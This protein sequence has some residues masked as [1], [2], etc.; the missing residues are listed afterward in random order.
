MQP[1]RW[2]ILGTGNIANQFAKGL[3]ALEDA[4]L[5]AIGSRRAESAHRF[6]DTYNVPNRH[7]SYEALAADP[8]VEIVYV[9]TPH[10]YHAEN[11]LLCLEAG[12]GVLCEKPFTLN[13][14]QARKVI[15]FARQRQLFLME[16]V[17]ARFLPHLDEAMRL[18]ADG[19]IGDVTML[20]ANFG[21][22]TS[23]DP[24]SRLFD[25]ALGG[26]A[27]LDVG[28]Y[29]VYLAHLLLGKP[30]EVRSLAHLGTTGVDE[31]A[32]FLF[33]YEGGAVAVLSTAIRADLPHTAVIAGTAG[34]IVLNERWWAPSSFTLQ[35]DGH[36][37]ETIT[38]E[39]VGNGYNYEAAEAGRCLRAGLLESEKLPHQLTLDV[40]LS[41]D[42]LRAEW[43]LKYPGEE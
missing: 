40:M 17:W 9:A 30:Q 18:V 43:G 29:P 21:F 32:A 39:I 28:I 27:L 10:V 14:A 42:A 34:R 26:G 20:Q 37:E 33:G 1:V 24:A 6:A 4:E 25:P 15:D 16:A 11:S 2:G 5:V 3:A 13:T 7:N 23:V 22:R 41:M 35:R 36:A 31:Q 38:P 8:N 12:K 19:A